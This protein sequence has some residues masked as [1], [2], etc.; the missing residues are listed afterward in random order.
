VEALCP[1]QGSSF[2]VGWFG[3]AA[4]PISM[5]VAILRYRLYEI[6]RIVA[7]TLAYAIV[8]GPPGRDHKVATLA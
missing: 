3:V 8:T 6:D 7:R 4:L 1:R 5:G 2:G